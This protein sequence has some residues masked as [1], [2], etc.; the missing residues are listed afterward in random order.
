MAKV[1]VIVPIYNPEPAFLEEALDSLYAQSYKDIEVIVVNDGSDRQDFRPLL[2]KYG[3]EIRYHEQENKGVADARNS[4]IAFSR[5]EYVGLLDQDDRWHPE[6]IE[7][8]MILFSRDPLLDVVIHRV[9]FIDEEGAIREQKASRVKEMKRRIRNRDI[10]AELLIGNFIY[11]P[12]ILIRS[13]CFD[14]VGGFDSTVDPHDDWDMWLR[15]AIAGCRF[16][17]ID[18]ELADWRIHPG[19]TSRNQRRMLLTNMSVIEKLERGGLIPDSHRK[20]VDRRFIETKTLLAHNSYSHAQYGRFRS[21]IREVAG[22][23]LSNIL[24]L[25]IMRRWVKSLIYERIRNEDG[26]S[27]L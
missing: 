25:K 7:K 8:Q 23:G 1:S 3:P 11:S 16:E 20:Y 13:A 12:A 2:E 22:F 15:L 4:G 17:A 18:E 24:K 27:G 19:N 14:K 6:K 26:N 5:G 21:E 9:N 10:L